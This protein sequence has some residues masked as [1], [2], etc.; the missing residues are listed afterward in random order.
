MLKGIKNIFNED[1]EYIET[2]ELEQIETSDPAFD[3]D[4]VVNTSKSRSIVKIYE[5]V[6]KSITSTII[7]SI[8][9]GELCVVNFAKVS[10]EE[11]KQIYATLSG[12]VYSLDG[13]LK[14]ISTDIVI[15]AP[16]NFL[17][18]GEGIE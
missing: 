16:K 14:Q 17:V 8:K 13:I 6:S 4:E 1:T 3:I 10:D 11:A 2:Q 15:C 9:V 5:P 18:D 7:D 12:S